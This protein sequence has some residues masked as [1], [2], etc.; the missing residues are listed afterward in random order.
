MRSRTATSNGEVEGPREKASKAPRAY[1]VFPRTRRATT[2]RSRTPPTIVRGAEL[3]AKDLR[4]S[5][6]TF[7]FFED[8]LGGY[9]FKTRPPPKLPPSYEKNTE[10]Y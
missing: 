7:K 6:V 4:F 2:D 8:L 10:Q 1:T 3:C 5:S 9:P